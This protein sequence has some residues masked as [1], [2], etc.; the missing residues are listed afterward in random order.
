[1]EVTLSTILDLFGS[2]QI[3]LTSQAMSFFQELYPPVSGG[4]MPLNTVCPNLGAFC[5]EFYI[6]AQMVKNPPAM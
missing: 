3:M 5:E 6:V 4:F 2:N 1:M